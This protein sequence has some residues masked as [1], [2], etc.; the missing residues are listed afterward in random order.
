[1]EKFEFKYF[2]Q[3]MTPFGIPSVKESTTTVYALNKEDAINRFKVKK[4]NAVAYEIVG[5]EK[6]E[7]DEVTESE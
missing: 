6:E 2:A 5:Y 7:S 4:K 3:V 1:M